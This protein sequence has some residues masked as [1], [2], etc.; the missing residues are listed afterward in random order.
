MEYRVEEL[1]QQ[2]VRALAASSVNEPSMAPT[3]TL[4]RTQSMPVLKSHEKAAKS[5]QSSFERLRGFATKVSVSNS[6]AKSAQTLTPATSPDSMGQSNEEIRAQARRDVEAEIS[7]YLSHPIV[8]TALGADQMMSFW[9]VSLVISFTTN[10]N[11]TIDAP[12]DLSH[13][14]E[15]CSRCPPCSSLISFLGASFLISQT[16]HNSAAKQNG[17]A[18]YRE[19]A[20]IEVWIETGG[21]VLDP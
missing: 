7:L 11:S 21:T 10:A 1:T 4:P 17:P 5:I 9:Q 2:R 6:R 16:Y 20:N 18:T 14:M 3:S 19:T 15:G 13:S 12:S 8:L